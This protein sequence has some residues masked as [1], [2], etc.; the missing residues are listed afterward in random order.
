MCFKHR[1]GYF[2]CFPKR[3]NLKSALGNIRQFC[4]PGIM[5]NYRLRNRI[6]VYKNEISK[7]L[8]V[9]KQEFLAQ[10]ETAECDN[11]NEL[12]RMRRRRGKIKREKINKY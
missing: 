9:Q 5:T 3:K 1:L 8:Y 7:S 10:T 12:C 4:S 11:N 2:F 6:Y